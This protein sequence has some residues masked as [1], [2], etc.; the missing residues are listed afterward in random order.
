MLL[1]DKDGEIY[2]KMWDFKEEITPL[3][4]V[5]TVVKARGTLQQY[6]GNDQFI[7]Q[8]LRATVEGDNVSVSDFVKSADITGEEMYGVIFSLV[9]SFTD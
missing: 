1:A 8:R 6:N 2:A 7:I 5:N 4:E 9:S 3:P